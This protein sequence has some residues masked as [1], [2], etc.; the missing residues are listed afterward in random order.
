MLCLVISSL[1]TKYNINNK[2]TVIQPLGRLLLV[3]QPRLV[4]DW[5]IPF[6][7]RPHPMEGNLWHRTCQNILFKEASNILNPSNAN[8]KGTNNKKLGCQNLSLHRGGATKKW[9]VP[10]YSG[11]LLYRHPFN[12]D[13]GLLQTVCLP[14]C[15]AHAFSLTLVFDLCKPSPLAWDILLFQ[16]VLHV[17]FLSLNIQLRR[18]KLFRLL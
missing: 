4:R 6:F 9:N 13:I 2:L 15:K 11:T 3:F 17:G 16:W 5:N 12:T 18:Y 10:L 8:F 7:M 14:R 1:I